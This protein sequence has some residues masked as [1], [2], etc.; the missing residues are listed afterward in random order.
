MSVQKIV[1]K[2][3]V[4]IEKEEKWLLREIRF[5]E[6]F[7]EDI[8]EIFE[9]H[10]KLST[11]Q[12]SAEVGKH[13][14]VEKKLQLIQELIERDTHKFKKFRRVLSRGERRR[15]R[16][17]KRVLGNIATIEKFLDNPKKKEL[18]SL[19][20]QVHVYS[21]RVL[22]ELSWRVGKINTLTQQKAP[23]IPQIKKHLDETN[24]ASK[25]L[26]A[27]LERLN[28]FMKAIENKVNEKK[29][30]QPILPQV[31]GL[32]GYLK[33]GAIKTAVVKSVVSLRY[34]LEK[35]ITEKIKMDLGYF[36]N[37][38]HNKIGKKYHQLIEE[39][40]AMLSKV[41]SQKDLEQLK[42][43]D[44]K[45]P[46]DG[47][48]LFLPGF[49]KPILAY[50][51]D[52]FPY[53][54]S[55]GWVSHAIPGENLHK[56]GK[57]RLLTSPLEMVYKK[58]KY[59]TEKEGDL[60][61]RLTDGISFSFQ[62]FMKYQVYMYNVSKGEIKKPTGGMFFFPMKSVL[63]EGLIFDFADTMD[64]WP[65]II[66]RDEA[67]LNNRADLIV[68]ML[69]S[70]NYYSMWLDNFND[71]SIFFK[72]C[73]INFKF[74]QELKASLKTK[75]MIQIK[76]FGKE[77][78]F[79]ENFKHLALLEEVNLANK[80]LGKEFIQKMKVACEKNN[81]SSECKRLVNEYEEKRRE[82][83]ANHLKNQALFK[84]KGYFYERLSNLYLSKETLQDLIKFITED[85]F[86]QFSFLQFSLLITH[87]K[88]NMFSNENA[89]VPPLARFAAEKKPLHLNGTIFQTGLNY[90]NYPAIQGSTFSNI[91]LTL[92][93]MKQNPS[94]F[95]SKGTY[96]TKDY[97]DVMKKMSPRKV[98]KIFSRSKAE[99]IQAME[100]IIKRVYR[101]HVPC[102]IDVKKGV[103]LV[104]E[105]NKDEDT[106][107]RLA[108]Q[109]VTIFTQFSND[110][111]S[112]FTKKEIEFFMK[113]ILQPLDLPIGR[114]YSREAGYFYLKGN[115]LMVHSRRSNRDGLIG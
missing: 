114:K 106:I 92:T 15:I 65:E 45:V 110:A 39:N 80:S 17:E 3:E 88:V 104:N 58:K 14:N 31:A 108:N 35:G 28:K 13:K 98:K 11:L 96:S 43:I 38:A 91:C 95:I 71:T 5:L 107:R 84:G 16:Y 97:V 54:T 64:G 32:T 37:Y 61:K 27:L 21:A 109:S 2:E 94:L 73:K 49:K 41:L 30:I 23:N 86:L 111:N 79:A 8:Q 99:L 12:K 4:N 59:F 105:S 7:K 22:T 42:N 113:N 34:F 63:A 33:E 77:I 72:E 19:I 6:H 67:Y 76:K 102:V 74:L 100:I 50:N 69:S 46:K 60:S 25:A 18:E 93:F 9:L 40:S 78:L 1:K 115:K 52:S 29:L 57:S 10:D 44:Y 47:T 89:F 90:L 53:F 26:V 62:E 70:I 101:S 68:K 48:L 51:I 55:R 81:N 82:V 112:H 56:V 36:N 66:L 103:L 20:E 87:Q 85:N 83:N 24:E 75:E